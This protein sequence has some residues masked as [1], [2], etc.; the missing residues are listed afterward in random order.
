MSTMQMPQVSECSVS[1]CS[2]N[3]DGCH[4]S[5]ITVAGSDGSA[6]CGTFIDLRAKGGLDTVL[7]EVGACHRTDCVHNAE[8]ECT[9]PSVRVGPGPDAAACL[10]FT[11]A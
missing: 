9:A 4:A 10:T 6:D 3:H 1:G 11:T 8:L 2:Y 5:A 7:A